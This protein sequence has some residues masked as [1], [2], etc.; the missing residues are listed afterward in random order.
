MAPELLD[1][2]MS[3]ALNT[4]GCVKFDIKAFDKTLHRTLTGI[5]N[6][7]TLENFERAAVGCAKRP[8]PPPLIASTLLVPGYID[9]AEVQA[10]AEF[11][12]A[13]DTDIPYSLLGFHPQ[14]EMRDLPPTSARLA[15]ACRQAAVDAGLTRV[16]IGNVHLLI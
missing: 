8:V 2:M 1:R 16:H 5:T 12:A 14:Y 4:G 13:I 11:I 10:I 9:A 15:E 6:R 7:R 3:M